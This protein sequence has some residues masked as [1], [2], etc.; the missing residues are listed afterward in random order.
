M[1]FLSLLGLDE[2]RQERLKQL[3]DDPRLDWDEALRYFNTWYD[4]VVKA[5]DAPSQAERAKTLSR[6]DEEVE[7]LAKQ[8][9][10]PPSSDSRRDPDVPKT[11]GRQFVCLLNSGGML[12]ARITL[13]AENS[14]LAHRG[15]ASLALALAAYRSDHGAYPKTLGELIPTYIA[16]ILKTAYGRRSALSTRRRRLLGLQRRAE[17]KR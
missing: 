16:D 13:N 2:S 4:R 7:T 12:T 8:A 3:A 17:W 1:N 5:H 11:L 9:A 15:L 6:I 10:V 14:S